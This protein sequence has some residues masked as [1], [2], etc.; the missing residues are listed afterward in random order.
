[1]LRAAQSS[2]TFAGALSKVPALPQVR[3]MDRDETQPLPKPGSD[4]D[5]YDVRERLAVGTGAIVYRAVE[6]GTDAEVL[7]KVL[8]PHEM[9]HPLDLA[10]VLARRKELARVKH[11][12]DCRAG[13]QIFNPISFPLEPL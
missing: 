12:N 6:I 5:A 3:S 13:R 2:V 9:A 4:A 11:P 10:C 8:H 7:F 1:M